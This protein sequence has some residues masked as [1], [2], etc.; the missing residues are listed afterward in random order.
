[1]D[2]LPSTSSS[3]AFC[4]PLLHRSVFLLIAL[5]AAT[6]PPASAIADE[7]RSLRSSQYL[8]QREWCNKYGEG[9]ALANTFAN[10]NCC[11]D[12]VL[13]CEN[14]T[15]ASRCMDPLD[16]PKWLIGDG[17]RKRLP[18]LQIDFA[19]AK[20]MEEGTLSS[21]DVKHMRGVKPGVQLTLADFASHLAAKNVN[22]PA[23][24]DA[25]YYPPLPREEKSRGSG[26]VLGG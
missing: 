22:M 16:F 26:L 14:F 3:S 11:T 8:L 18:S 15:G 12:S 20:M 13:W 17:Q 24:S 6:V 7:Q 21:N 25:H 19:I 5:F 2:S 10:G 9:C 23:A 1:M 4:L